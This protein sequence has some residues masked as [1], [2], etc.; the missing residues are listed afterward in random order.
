VS[1]SPSASGPAFDAFDAR[2]VLYEDA[3]TL[4]IDK[5]AGL[6]VD[7]TRDPR[8]PFLVGLASAWLAERDGSVDLRAV[9]RLD[10]MTSGV[11]VLAKTR[12]RTT[13]LMQAFEG[14]AVEKRYV[15]I[16]EGV[17]DRDRWIERNYLVHRRGR[18]EAVRS[19]GRL[20]ETELSV[21]ARGDGRALLEARPITGRTHQIRVH[22]AD[23]GYPILGDPLYGRPSPKGPRGPTTG[24]R[25]ML[26][27]R[28]LRITLSGGTALELDAP[29]P[30]DF[31]AFIPR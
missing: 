27:A 12:A 23:A 10:A 13:E 26:H 1:P 2:W 21:L 30:P 16:V 17:P 6:V 28:R 29:A 31:D 15:A 25:L 5:P 18:T 7:A 14:R 24:E 3:T 11:I 8:R 22:L 20:A 4:G 19:G 9:H